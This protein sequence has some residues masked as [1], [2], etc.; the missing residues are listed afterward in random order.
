MGKQKILARGI[1]SCERA[2]P[3]CR[4]VAIAALI[5]TAACACSGGGRIATF[6][7]PIKPLA[8][9]CNPPARAYLAL[10]APYVHFTPWE[11]VLTLDG[12]LAPDGTI[13]ATA[14]TTGLDHV[15]YHQV[16][17]AS[18]AGDRITGTYITPRCR[19][20]VALSATGS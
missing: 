2:L 1:F 10:N 7:G 20:Q 3:A 17:Y 4:A 5:V 11:G 16:L 14:V 9:T 8:G 15:P 19:Y 13:Q 6:T 12:T 18:L